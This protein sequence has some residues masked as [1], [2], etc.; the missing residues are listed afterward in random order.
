MFPDDLRPGRCGVRAFMKFQ[1]KK[2]AAA[3]AGEY[4]LFLNCKNQSKVEWSESPIRFSTQHMG[5][6]HIGTMVSRQIQTIGVD[7]KAQK[8]SSTSVR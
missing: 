2:P 8:I 5:K 1:S 7:T 3:K 6:D 4:K